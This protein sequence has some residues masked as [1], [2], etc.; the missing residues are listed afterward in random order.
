MSDTIEGRVLAWRDPVKGQGPTVN[1]RHLRRLMKQ[2]PLSSTVHG[3]AAAIEI[4][5]AR[6]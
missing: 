3:L 4:E 1:V 6:P 5:S 2:V